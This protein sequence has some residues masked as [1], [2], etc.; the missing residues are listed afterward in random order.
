M[1]EST[2]TADAAGQYL[3]GGHATVDDVLEWREELRAEGAPALAR[4][5]SRRLAENFIKG[6]ALTADQVDAI[7]KAC[8]A[9]EAFSHARRVLKR[10]LYPDASTTITAPPADP[11]K[12]PTK[13]KLREQLALMTSKDPDLAASVRHDWALAILDANLEKSSAET[14]GIAGGIL[15]RRWEWDGRTA[16]LEQALL[17]YLAPIERGLTDGMAI[18]E[19]D[20]DGRGVTAEDGYPAINAA[21]VCDLLA[22]QTDDPTSQKPTGRAPTSCASGS[23]TRSSRTTT[24]PTRRWPKP[25]SDSATSTRPSPC[26]DEPRN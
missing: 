3:D 25:G 14:L 19:H 13:D 8:K 22:E 24:G 10:R 6:N 2:T 26:S 18:E 20:R 4:A 7:W 23:P 15:K 11:A 17:H 9:D 5:L 16:S 12:A 1:A 21:F